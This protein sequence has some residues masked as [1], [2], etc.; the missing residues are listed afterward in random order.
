MGL[1]PFVDS[2]WWKILLKL[3]RTEGTPLP[4][5]VSPMA[6]HLAISGFGGAQG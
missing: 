3:R 2:V 5:W 6:F 1:P 4:F